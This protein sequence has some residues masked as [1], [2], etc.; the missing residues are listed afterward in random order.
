MQ[1]ISA[2]AV[3]HDPQTCSRPRALDLSGFKAESLIS[4]Q[5]A[6]VIATHVVLKLLCKWPDVCITGFRSIQLAERPW[7]SYLTEFGLIPGIVY[8]GERI[9]KLSFSSG[10]VSSRVLSEHPRLRN[11]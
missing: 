1:W 4:R 6:W 9:D 3:Y 2:L 10:V 7:V 5:M 8:V 11:A